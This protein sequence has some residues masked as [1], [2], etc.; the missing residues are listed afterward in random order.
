MTL[1]A[2]LVAVIA[3]WALALAGRRRAGPLLALVGATLGTLAKG[4]VALV[5]PALAAAGLVAVRADVR[6]LRVVI[7]LAI[8]ATLAGAW[9][10][11]AFRREGTAFLAI[12]ARENMLRFVDTTEGQTGHAHGPAYLVPLGLVGLLP[13]TPVLA[14]AAVPLAGRPRQA[15][16]VF[17]ASWVVTGIVFFTLAAGKRSVYLL[18]LFPAIAFL[19]GAGATAAPAGRLARAARAGGRLYAPAAALVAAA[20]VALATG[21]DVSAPIRRWLAPADAAGAAVV[22][23]AVRGEAPRFVALAVATV[24]VAAFIDHA[25][26]RSAWRPLVLGVAAMFA[27]WTAAFDGLVHP[28]IA[29]ARSLAPFLATVARTVPPGAP[30]YA[31]FPADPGLRFY[32]PATLRPLPPDGAFRG[33]YV[34][35]WEDEW[36]RMR[37][38][39]GAELPV[40][41][42]SDVGQPRRGRLALVA[43]PDPHGGVRRGTR[44]R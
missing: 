38:A 26:R 9:Y 33:G 25:A 20:T 16:A 14:L 19:A 18:P 11:V 12:V 36:H 23:A 6:P 41:A 10:A 31:R 29:R 39:S 1:A 32:A 4:P 2:P 40:V 13:W 30:L 5:L 27:A 21:V 22:A 37:D 24:A 7:V 43:A 42:L 28:T 17:C 3:G 15:V 8:A 34:L 44:S 35:L